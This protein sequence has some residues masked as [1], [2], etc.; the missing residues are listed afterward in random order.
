MCQVTDLSTNTVDLA[1]ESSSG[2]G[3]ME[4]E[5]PPETEP[6]MLVE[7]TST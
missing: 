7:D 4:E 3:K 2:D 6:E 1:V 5:K